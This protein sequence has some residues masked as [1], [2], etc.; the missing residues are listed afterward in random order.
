MV[1]Y[2]AERFGL[3]KEKTGKTPYTMNQR[4]VKIHQLQQELWAL[5]KQYK[6]AEEEEIPPLSELR[7]ILRKKLMTLRRAVWH[8][9][10]GRKRARK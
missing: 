6:H 5:K 9:S 2:G 7:N 4:P 8:R 10:R 3:V 1:S